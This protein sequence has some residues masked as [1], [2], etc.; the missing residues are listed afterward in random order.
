MAAVR[1]RVARDLVLLVERLRDLVGLL[2]GE[3]ELGAAIL[4]QGG[5][6]VGQGRRLLLLRDRE[7]LDG[8][9]APLDLVGDALGHRLVDQAPVRVQPVVVGRDDPCRL[10]GA[11]GVPERPRRQEVVD[12]DELLDLA[13][14]V[15]D[16]PEGRGLHAPDGERLVEL[17]A[18]AARE[19]RVEPGHV[20]PVHPVRALAAQGRFVEVALVG[21][22]EHRLQRLDLLRGR[23]VGDPEA[24]DVGAERVDAGLHQHLVDEELA[25]AAGVAH[26]DE[27]AGVAQQPVDLLD[28]VGLALAVPVL[29]GL[30]PPA[31]RHDGQVTDVPVLVAG[32]VVVGGRLLVHV[33][34]EPAD[35]V[36]AYLPDAAAL[37]RPEAELLRPRLGDL[38][39]EGRLL[40]DEEVGVHGV[41]GPAGGGR[42]RMARI[43]HRV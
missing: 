41:S 17:P 3:G 16:E 25:L 18:R 15:D 20:E 7:A 28:P 37:G 35:G 11:L 22:R 5:Q 39:G 8:P 36:L 26:P 23:E 34:R 1:A 10:E 13:V 38:L 12:R 42:V 40:R 4:L 30:Q 21:V 43:D 6:R 32:V 31:V 24:E 29:A 27:V 2:G 9:G 14:P 33:A 19:H